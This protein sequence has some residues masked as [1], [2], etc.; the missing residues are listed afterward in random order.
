[1]KKLKKGI[2][3]FNK[4]KDY[5]INKKV[6]NILEK[7]ASKIDRYR[8]R[9]LYH[10]NSES[11]PQ[12]MLI[13]FDDRSIVPVSFH[14][15]AESFSIIK[16]IAHYK[17]Y[18]LKGN[19]KHDIRLAP[20]Y[21]DGNFYVAIAPL[22]PHRFFSITKY[23]LANE[24]GFTH[25]S[26]EL[27]KFGKGKQFFKANKETTKQ[28]LSKPLVIGSHTK[29]NF[30]RK[31]YFSFGSNDG[32]AQLSTADVVEKIKSSEN[33]V[34][35]VVDEKIVGKKYK[36]EIPE[37][38]W[39]IKPGKKINLKLKH[40]NSIIHIMNGIGELRLKDKRVVL[41]INKNFVLNTHDNKFIHIKNISENNLILHIS[42]EFKFKN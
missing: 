42:N 11:N 17:F 28:M 32:I 15:F 36:K 5:L 27:T 8:S 12:H 37:I 33:A 30:L 16:G 21:L 7:D 18:D 1:M 9:I 22:T 39:A 20:P 31:N 29:F 25:F 3:N 38:I 34:S 35:F 41:D 40:Q 2:Y 23:V 10:E 14:K 24:I 13:C 19:V 4:K 6:L 26:T